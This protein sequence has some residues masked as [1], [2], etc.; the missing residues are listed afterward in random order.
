MVNE[1]DEYIKVLDKPATNRSN[2]HYRKVYK[3]KFS[4]FEQDI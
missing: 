4:R 2:M 1:L 3:L